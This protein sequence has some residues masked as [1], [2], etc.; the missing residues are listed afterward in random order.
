VGPWDAVLVARGDFL[1]GSLTTDGTFLYALTGRMVDRVDPGGGVG[2]S[3]PYA[4]HALAPV[5]TSADQHLWVASFG[6]RRD[7]VM[8]QRYDTPTLTPS[9]RLRLSF[10]HMAG[11][12]PAMAVSPDGA[13]LYVGA[14]RSVAIIDPA[15]VRVLSR[16]IVPER[17]VTGLAVNPDGTTLYVGTEPGGGALGTIAVFDLATATLTDTARGTLGQGTLVATHGGLWEV[18]GTGHLNPVGFASYQDL[19]HP[20]P[21]PS[22]GGGIYPTITIAG[23]TAWIGGLE[24]TCADANSGSV[25]SRAGFQDSQ[26][27]LTATIASITTTS[28]GILYGVYQQFS[29][30]QYTGVVHVHAPATCKS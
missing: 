15:G 1:L 11:G 4:L 18:G 13:R 8:L 12:A 27:S 16:I 10:R 3:A 14:G 22:G 9:G 24:L 19:A 7:T 21:E 20:R 2:A 28:D 29:P 23:Q 6:N 30:S 17:Y 25:R 26:G 5:I